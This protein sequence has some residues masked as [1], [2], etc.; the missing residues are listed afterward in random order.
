MVESIRDKANKVKVHLDGRDIRNIETR[1]PR[2]SV[3]HTKAKASGRVVG[4]DL[5]AHDVASFFSSFGTISMRIHT[6]RGMD[7]SGNR[8]HIPHFKV[9]SEG[10]GFGLGTILYNSF[11][12]YAIKSDF[13]FVSLRVGGGQDTKDFL[14]KRGM[15]P[16]FLHVHSF[17]GASKVS[18]VLTT[19]KG[20]MNI[21]NLRS[22][23]ETADSIEGVFI[24]DA[25]ADI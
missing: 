9:E 4:Y 19:R 6:S 23:K 20:F 16:E 18:V 15:N 24:E 1:R 17:P 8:L 3:D 22:V 2:V 21:R 11:K 7:I 5:T 13:D 14:V 12:Q 25:F 10:R